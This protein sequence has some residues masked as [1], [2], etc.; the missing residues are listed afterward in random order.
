MNGTGWVRRGVIVR[1]LIVLAVVPA[2]AGC[3]KSRELE[4]ANECDVSLYM[5]L[6]YSSFAQFENVQVLDRYSEVV[7][8]GQTH[9]YDWDTYYKRAYIFAKVEGGS[10]G[11]ELPLTLEEGDRNATMKL[12]ISGDMCETL[13]EDARPETEPSPSTNPSE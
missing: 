12:S 7:E 4:V 9:T 1:G 8:P 11:F 2:L 13:E 6:N 10:W 5:D 3:Q